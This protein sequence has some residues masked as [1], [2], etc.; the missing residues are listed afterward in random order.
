M[1][2]GKT[3]F[4]SAADSMLRGLI[5][6]AVTVL[7]MLAAAVFMVKNEILKNNPERAGKICLLLGAVLCGYVN[8]RRFESGKILYALT[9]EAIMAIALI[10][11]EIICG[12][13]I[14]KVAFLR[15][16]I[17]IIFGGFAGVLLTIKQRKNR[18]KKRYY[19]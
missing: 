1:S 11:T 8:G 16:L 7:L 18:R 19:K 10:L 2:D 14:E 15:G 13:E 6:G 9:G 12:Q 17:I 3:R 4:S 5:C